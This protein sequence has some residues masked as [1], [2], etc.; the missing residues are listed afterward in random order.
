MAKKEKLPPLRLKKLP[1]LRL[2]SLRAPEEPLLRCRVTNNPVGTD[3]WPEGL[4]CPCNSCQFYLYS[5]VVE[6]PVPLLRVEEGVVP[7]PPPEFSNAAYLYL[8]SDGTYHRERPT[9]ESKLSYTVVIY[10]FATYERDVQNGAAYAS[11]GGG[12]MTADS[13][14]RKSLPP[15]RIPPKVEGPK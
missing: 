5:W 10:D 8:W 4:E 3:T 12:A 14:P 11:R 6:V 9:E 1:P 7:I 2:S 13:R 15:L